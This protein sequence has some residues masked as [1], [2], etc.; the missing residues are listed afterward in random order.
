M[1][2]DDASSLHA[3]IRS[4]HPSTTDSQELFVNFGAEGGAGK[5]HPSPLD[6]GSSSMNQASRQHFYLSGVTMRKST[7]MMALLLL[8]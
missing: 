8:A 3:A 7:R 4:S 1:D 5:G 6:L 2:G